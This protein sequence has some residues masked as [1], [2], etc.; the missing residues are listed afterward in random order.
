MILRS[1][2]NIKPLYII[3]LALLMVS[4]SSQ[5]ASPNQMQTGQLRPTIPPE[6][7]TKPPTPIITPSALAIAQAT[8]LNPVDTPTSRAEP[9]LP[10]E[11]D[12]A[13]P[14]IATNPTSTL[15]PTPFIVPTAAL[16]RQLTLSAL[17][18]V[19][20]DLANAV[21]QLAETRPND[22]LWVEPGSA[23]ADISLQ[24]GEGIPLANWVYVV[25]APFPTIA[26]GLTFEDVQARWSGESSAE[27]PLIVSANTAATF[28][29]TWGAPAAT[30]L[31]HSSDD[32]NETLWQQRPSL[33]ILPFDK[34]TAD[35]K[36]L[37]LD[38]ISPLWSD[39]TTE[40]YPLLVTVGV[41]GEEED[42]S[43]FL[44]AWTM[45]STNRDPAKLTHVAMTGVTALVRATASQ[46]ENDGILT[47]A[48]DVGPVLQA[49]DITHISNEVSFAEDCPEPSPVGGTTFCSQD[50]YFALLQEIG[51]DVVELTGNHVN[52]WGPDSMKHSLELYEGSGMIYFGGGRDQEDAAQPALFEHNANKIA[53]VGCNPVGPNYA[54][55]G[56]ADPGSR[57]CGP[58]F[59]DQIRS[60]VEQGYLVIAT[61]QY[62]EFYHY[63]A[64]SQQKEDFQAL[65]DAGA[66]AVSGSQGHHAQGFDFHNGAFIH[67]GLGNL[68]F[69]QMDMLGTRQTFVDTYTI[70]DGRLLNVELWTGLIEDFF[71]PRLMTAEE[72][73]QALNAVFSASGW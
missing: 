42:I 41:S 28:A 32:L 66:A 35:L 11:G 53:F 26:D 44:S 62:Y 1:G 52:D 60:L 65:V 34:L 18:G 25:A 57:A 55:A 2:H 14:T 13:I 17:P 50:D 23:A 63:A 33:A 5:D 56:S 51:T 61:Q 39:F 36:A 16:P 27:G 43:S 19:P 70:Y 49:A 31:Q 58:E 73:E 59:R 69:D 72:R 48:E 64:T 54:W 7:L 71:K 45:P 21:R 3:F 68:F 29:P 15:T 6:W 20:A 67:Y 24:V 40:G 8:V 37:Q 22:F 38:G 46:M 10:A 9:T 12:K 30:V 47:P 4:C